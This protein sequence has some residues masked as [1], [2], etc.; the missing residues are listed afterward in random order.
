MKICVV[1]L[2]EAVNHGAFLQAYAMKKYLEEKGHEVFFLKTYSWKMVKTM[3][4]S[5]FSYNPKKW[6]FKRD[7]RKSYRYAQ[8]LLKKTTRKNGYDMVVIG[9]DEVWQLRNSTAAPKE[10]FFGL[11]FD[12][13]IIISYAACSNNTQESDIAKNDFVKKGLERCRY[14]SV[15]D[16]RTYEVYANV[17]GKQLSKVLDPTFLVDWEKE[18]IGCKAPKEPYMLVYTYGFGE[19]KIEN[20]KAYAKA[21]GLKLISFG[22]KFDWCDDS[23]AGTAFDFLNYI[24]HAECV[25]TDT[26]HG[27][28][29]SLQQ[30]KDLFIYGYKQ[31]VNQ[32]IKQFE[33]EQR[34][35]NAEDSLLER[36]AVRID[37]DRVFEIVE[38]EKTKSF[39]FL[40]TALNEAEKE[41]ER[42]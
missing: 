22:P 12:A 23:C 33:L 1:T 36:D 8:S 40:Q 30:K 14:L 34:N 5:L 2:C 28:I 32:V 37:Y 17:A 38:R 4:R 24:R 15:R 39:D 21:K 41:K 16:D 9:S 19:D 11:G 7:F 27:S 13:P 20:V 29:L 10:E 25:V 31:K 18:I 35:L 42:C 3:L 6:T 26:F